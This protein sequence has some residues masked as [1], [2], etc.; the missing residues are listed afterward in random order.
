MCLFR[1]SFPS[2]WVFHKEHFRSFWIL[3][4]QRTN[5]RSVQWG[6]YFGGGVILQITSLSIFSKFQIVLTFPVPCCDLV[7]LYDEGRIV[8]TAKY[9]G[10][11]SKFTLSALKIQSN[12]FH[13]DRFWFRSEI[14]K[15]TISIK[16]N[17]SAWFSHSAKFENHSPR[18]RTTCWPLPA[19]MG[20]R[21]R[22]APAS[23]LG[24]YRFSK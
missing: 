18:G 22:N 14:H 8:S 16:K 6:K 24:N 7:A 2:K 1:S 9:P 20:Q 15:L 4:H 5:Y 21:N 12:N 13:R 3:E 17:Y 19:F 10:S 23:R 11:V